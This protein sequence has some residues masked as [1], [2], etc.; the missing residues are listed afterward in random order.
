MKYRLHGTWFIDDES[1][2]IAVKAWSESQNK[3]L[4]FQGINSWEQKLN[5]FIDVAGEYVKKWQHVWYNILTFLAKLQNL[6]IAPRSHCTTAQTI[7]FRIS[8]ISKYPAPVEVDNSIGEKFS[9][10]HVLPDGKQPICIKEKMTQF[11]SMVLAVSSPTR[12]TMNSTRLIKERING[13]A[14]WGSHQKVC[15]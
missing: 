13:T 10:L 4:Y 2:K 15:W 5:I 14:S 3:K 11:S 6:L 12:K 9:C 8:V 1:L 7:I